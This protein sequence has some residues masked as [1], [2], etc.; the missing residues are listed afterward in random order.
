MK[1]K[2]LVVCVLAAC[3]GS[4]F[5]EDA[6]VA[7]AVP[8]LGQIFDASG[9][10]VTGYMDMAYNKMDTTGLFTNSAA[11]PITGGAPGN[12]RIFDT[13]SAVK[14]QN[15]NSFNFNQAAVIVSKLPKEGLGGL[16]NITAGQDAPT[17]ASTGL[18]TTNA[19][20][21]QAFVNYASGALTVQ[22]GKFA[23]LAGAELITSPA[24]LNYSR[25]WMFGWGPYTHTGLRATYVANDMFTLIGG[26]NNGFDQVNSQQ[27]GKMAELNLTVTANP[28][29]SL[30]TTLL[31]GKQAGTATGITGN[32]DYLDMVGTITATSQLKFVF[33]YAYGKQKDA[34]VIGSDAKWHALAS[35]VN[36]QFDDTWRVAYRNEAFDDPNGFRSG[37]AQNLSSNTLTVGYAVSKALEIRGEYRADKSTQNSFLQ[38]SGLGTSGQHSYAVDAVYQF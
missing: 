10:S 26:V 8:T 13:P 20:I 36:Y 16:I 23:T 2:A 32:R 5:A 11:G 38:S 31:S 34:M 25:A 28:M 18:S 27:S 1:K 4:A 37:V 22:A 9:L 15:F 24:N 30:A 17:V 33:D 35:Y 14:G 29:F 6:H 3:S 19:D 7:P 21:T 12:T